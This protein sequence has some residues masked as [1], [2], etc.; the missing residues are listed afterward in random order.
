MN[1]KKDLPVIALGAIAL[2]LLADAACSCG[3]RRQTNGVFVMTNDSTANAVAAFYLH[4]DGELVSTGH[5]ETTGAGVGSTANPLRSQGALAI[6]RDGL[7][8]VALNAGSNDISSFMVENGSLTLAGKVSSKGQYPISAAID[9][10]RVFVLNSRGMNPSITGFSI[11]KRGELSAINKDKAERYLKPGPHYSQIGI[12]PNGRWLVVC[13]ETDNKLLVYALRGDTIA[14][15]MRTLETNG[16]GPAAFAFD[17]NNNLLVVESG[18]GTVSSYSISNDSIQI[19]TAALQTDQTMPRWIACNGDYAYTAATNNSFITA[20]SINANGQLTFAGKY[21][22][23]STGFTELA[24]NS[25]KTFLYTFNPRT[26]VISQFVIEDDGS[27]TAAA[28][29]TDYFGNSAQGI[30]AN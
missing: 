6:S 8:L 30:A 13:N 18:S 29:I 23:N 3:H 20:I 19:I 26:N 9:G 16:T 2:P 1:V 5:T 4:E 7:W 15:E 21:D 12:S 10:N 27:L 22:T 24:I 28:Q 25:D 17:K 14:K 11:G